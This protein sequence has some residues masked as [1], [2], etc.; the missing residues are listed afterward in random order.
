MSVAITG[1]WFGGGGS[2]G[3]TLASAAGAAA[4]SAE[5]L[6]SGLPQPAQNCSPCALSVPQI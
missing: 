2:A 3:R 6:S 4:R 1:P 5:A